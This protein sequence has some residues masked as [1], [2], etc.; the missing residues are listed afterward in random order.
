M[1][2]TAVETLFTQKFVAEAAGVARTKERVRDLLVNG[3]G[4]SDGWVWAEQR[5]GGFGLGVDCA[6]GDSLVAHVER[7]ARCRHGGDCSWSSFDP[8]CMFTF[9]DC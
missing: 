6:G 1:R 4:R 8:R 5:K 2:G 3:V 7:F 9:C